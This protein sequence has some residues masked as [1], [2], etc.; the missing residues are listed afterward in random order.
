MQPD[1]ESL[2]PLPPVEECWFLTGPTASGKTEVG[3]A[4]AERIGAEIISLD[5]MAVYRGMDIGTAKPSA[6]QM[7]RTPHHLINIRPPTDDFSLSEYVTAAHEKIREIKDRGRRVLFVGGTPLYL[8]SL[9]RGVYEGPP[10]DWDF[11]NAVEQEIENVGLDALRERLKMVDPLSAQKLHPNDKRRMIRALEVYHLTG[12]PISHQQIQFEEGRSVDECLVFTLCW[13][14]FQLHE[15]IDARVEQMFEA[16]L[17]DEVRG[18]LDEFGAL[19]RTAAQALGYREVL[20]YVEQGEAGDLPATIEKVKARTRQFARR[21]ETWFRSLSECRMIDC[22]HDL[23]VAGRGRANRRILALVRQLADASVADSPSKAKP[24]TGKRTFRQL[25]GLARMTRLPC[26]PTLRRCSTIAGRRV[27]TTHS[28][29]RPLLR[30]H[31]CGELRSDHVGQEVTLCGWVD[32]NR[33]HGRGVF[34]DVRDRYGMT[35]VVAAPEAGDAA[36]DLAK[37]LRAEDVVL[38]RGKVANRPEGTTNPNLSTGEIEVR[39]VEIQVLN[40]SATPPFQPTGVELPG[41]DL[42]LK[43]RYL[44]LRRPVMQQTMILRS[45]IIKGMR[46]YFEEHDFIDVETPVLGRSTPEGARDYLVPSRIHHGSFYALPQ[47]PQLY[48]QILMVAGYDRYVQVA[49]CFRD[50]DLRADRQPEFTQLDVE[51]SFVDADDV[52]GI[53]DGLVQRLA[54]DLLGLDVALPLPRM[55]YD[56]AMER[57]GHDAPDLRFGMELI[58]CSDIAAKTEFRVFRGAVDGGGRVRGINAKNCADRY[59]RRLI[60]EMTEYVKQDFGAKGLAWFRVEDDGSLWSPIAKNFQPEELEAI[61][62]RMGAEPNDLL[63]FIAD[64]FDVSCKALYGLRKRLGAE[65]ELYDPKAMHFSWVV[66]FPMF[67]MDEEEQRWNAMHHPF[68]APRDQDVALL[69]SDP[70]KCRAKAYD[71]VINGSEAGGGTTRIH[72]RQVQ[73]DV[74]DLL[75][76]DEASAAERFGF[77]LDALQFGAPPHGGI[78]LGIDRWVMLFAGLDNIRDCIAFPKTQR[79]TDLMTDAPGAVDAKQL[80]ELGIRVQTK[81][82]PPKN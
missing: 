18:L 33:D 78:A 77:L 38:F 76:L 49:R 46:D 13:S 27:E 52:M 70:G 62:E 73:S 45:Q 8:K 44:D 24:A 61:K 63:L 42:R 10:A 43:Y 54:K 32:S 57:F 3:L 56:E 55:T 72:D 22:L 50:E 28:G 5:S 20:E 11:R 9:L 67:D 82:A 40:K 65:L 4:L 81:P 47:S 14:R 29:D 16:G 48:K 69:K 53:I 26:S 51:M 7:G 74:F 41:E 35:Q 1:D 68:T 58:C 36:V 6:E 19:S 59:S 66:E 79:A 25:A 60:D 12:Q 34:I 17:V 15:R 31:T 75:G 21:Q 80:D 39:A 64:S 23:D 71:L 30:T 37:S 2:Q